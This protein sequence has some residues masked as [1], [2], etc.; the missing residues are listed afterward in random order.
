VL[1]RGRGSGVLADDVAVATIVPGAQGA[2]LKFTV[3]VRRGKSRARL[4]PVPLSSAKHPAGLPT[5]AVGADV[6]RRT[7]IRAAVAGP[8][9]VTDTR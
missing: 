3:H 2:T 9:F 1:L 5:I 6:R 7:V 4:Q 8:R